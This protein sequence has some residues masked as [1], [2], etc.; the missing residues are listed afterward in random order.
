VLLDNGLEADF[1]AEENLSFTHRKIAGGADIYFVANTGNKRIVTPATFRAHGKGVPQLWNPQNGKRIDAPI[2]EVNKDETTRLLLS[3]APSESVFVIFP[4]NNNNRPYNEAFFSIERDGVEIYSGDASKTNTVAPSPNLEILR[5]VY[6]VP[7][8]A[9]HSADVTSIVRQLAKRN[10]RH[11]R[12]GDVFVAAGDVAPNFYKTL[13]IDFKLDGVAKQV[14]VKHVTFAGVETA[15]LIGGSSTAAPQVSGVEFCYQTDSDDPFQRLRFRTPGK[16]VLR[17]DGK[18]FEKTV[19]P[20]NTLPLAGDWTLTFPGKSPLNL[21]ELV[22]WPSLPD[23]E[24]KYFSGTAS[25]TKTFAVPTDF[26]RDGQRLILNLGAVAEIAE[27]FINDKKIDTLW[28][29]EKRVDITG[30]VRSGET[31][32]LE[33]RITNL[34]QNRLIG[35]Q[36]FP[37][38]G[39]AR[40]GDGVLES[41]PEWYLTNTPNPSQRTTFATWDLY[42]KTDPLLPS[43]L[44]GPVI[45]ETL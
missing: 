16:Y 17:T 33:I 10:P 23:P 20:N 32:R 9:A 14:S 4:E 43:G 18:V 19:A 11:V 7:G 13:T 41:W 44:L 28:M 6:G 30:I 35:D 31:A 21:Q 25:Y 5:A 12:V 36:F 2:W 39:V 8:D 37:E 3:L 38:V 34:L 26:V 27:V 1:V 45:L 42:K 15:A 29:P 24:H 40:R 22:S